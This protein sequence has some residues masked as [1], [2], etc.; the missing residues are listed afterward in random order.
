MSWKGVEF[1]S[2]PE[3]R[4]GTSRGGG[5]FLDLPLLQDHLSRRQRRRALVVPPT[6]SRQEGAKAPARSVQFEGRR[7][8]IGL[9]LPIGR[10]QRAERPPGLG[11]RRRR[12]A[13]RPPDG[14]V[15]RDCVGRLRDVISD[16][17]GS[18]RRIAIEAQLDDE[19][20]TSRHVE[21]LGSA[22]LLGRPLRWSSRHPSC[23]FYPS[24]LL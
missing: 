9:L 11:P 6:A 12:R 2:S 23:Q 5:Q 1:C 7:G 24:F 17:L 8:G 20:W 22:L 16:Q 3:S 19:F 10:L 18:G 4:P 13:R 15:L 14:G 21:G